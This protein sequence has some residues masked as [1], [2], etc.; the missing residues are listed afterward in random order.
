MW[1][2]GSDQTEAVFITEVRRT[3]TDNLK[4]NYLSNTD[5][6][7]MYAKCFI[8][9]KQFYHIENIILLHYTQII[10]VHN[11]RSYQKWVNF[12]PYHNLKSDFSQFYHFVDLYLQNT[13][14]PYFP[15]N[16]VK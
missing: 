5:L 3:L 1:E 15:Q 8:P 12:I 10:Y 13:I 4:T 16:Y 14:M 7:Q 9:C 11:N 2:L 6:M